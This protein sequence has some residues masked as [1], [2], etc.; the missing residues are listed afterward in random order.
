MARALLSAADMRFKGLGVGSVLIACGVWACG[1]SAD[2]GAD[3]PEPDRNREPLRLSPAPAGLCGG[4]A[5]PK[6]CKTPGGCAPEITPYDDGATGSAS[7]GEWSAP[8]TAGSG[9]EPQ[10]GA[11]GMG[12]ASRGGEGGELETASG[13]AGARGLD[14]D[15]AS[16]E[17]KALD[18]S[19]QKLDQAQPATLY[20]S[21]DDSA[22]MASPVLARHLIRS[23]RRVPAG[24]IRPYEFLNYY[25]FSFEPAE[26]G[27]VRVVPQLSSCP[28]G[29]ELSFQVAL[30]SEAREPSQ[31]APLNLTLVLD[32][33]GSMAGTPIELE[34]AAVRA[35]AGQLRA[36]DVVSVVTWNTDQRDLL[37]SHVVSE[38]PDPELLAVA[39]AVTA[40]GGTDLDGGLRRGYQLAEAQWS[41][42]RIN[43]VIVVSDG[44]ANVGETN[45]E[46]IA[47]HANDEEGGTGIYLAGVGVGDGVNDTLLNVVTDAGRGAY[48]YLDSKEEAE[49]ML[50]QRFLSVVDVAARAVRLELELPWYFQVHKFFGEII[51]TDASKVYPQHLGPN[52]AMMFFQIIKACDPALIDGADEIA[53]RATWETPF[54]R[55]K[56]EHFQKVSLNELAG[57]EATLDK[58]AAIAGYAEALMRFDLET[59]SSKRE[60]VVTEALA[61]VRAVPKY[62]ADPDLAEV[63]GLL[64][65]LPETV[66]ADAFD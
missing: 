8:S 28:L 38:T 54:T 57:N 19:C 53:L 27:Q 59:D 40:S 45:A 41:E 51:S 25:D 17:A 24:S 4:N 2:G 46:L 26:P 29:G 64:E 10:G 42:E 58:A 62:Q 7:G 52:D 9:G 55:E 20:L 22:S 34:Q 5:A 48:V 56:R 1:S 15:G 49:K 63:I 43:R 6:E 13:A 14:I 11:G 60:Q 47:Q 44:I 33:S 3:Q 12:G 30:Q 37:T 65:K 39:D 50:G 18:L 21:A 16:F 23:G 35:I 32:T 36:G 66:D 61:N 31:R